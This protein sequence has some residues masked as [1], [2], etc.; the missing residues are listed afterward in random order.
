MWDAGYNAWKAGVHF[1]EGECSEWRA[2]WRAAQDEWLD[3][4]DA[5]DGLPD[6]AAVHLDDGV[7]CDLDFAAD[8][9]LPGLAQSQLP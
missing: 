6:G 7:D 1:D 4:M 8:G 9:V 5:C 3:E 2:G